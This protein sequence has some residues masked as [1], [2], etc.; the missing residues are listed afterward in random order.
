MIK[1]PEKYKKPLLFVMGAAFT[2]GLVGIP[3]TLDTPEY[4][5]VS[6]LF[7]L[8]SA[9]LLLLFHQ[10]ERK[11]L[12]ITMVLVA[13]LGWLVEVIGVKTGAVFGSYGYGLSLGPKVLDV[14]VLIGLNWAM[15]IYMTFLATAMLPLTNRRLTASAGLMVLYDIMLEPAASKLGMWQFANN[16]VPFQNYVVWFLLSMLFLQLVRYSK[17]SYYNPIAVPLFWMQLI[18]FMLLNIIFFAIKA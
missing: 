12:A 11:R 14:P 4:F 2:V 9:V 15:L 13:F 5:K 16:D 1:Q 6:S 8:A 7:L 3:M 10:G 18:F 17:A